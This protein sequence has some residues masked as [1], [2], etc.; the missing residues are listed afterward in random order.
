MVWRWTCSFEKYANA[1]KLTVDQIKTMLD[2]DSDIVV[3]ESAN[4]ITF[5][6]TVVVDP[7][8]QLPKGDARNRYIR[9]A[10]DKSKQQ[11][12]LDLTAGSQFGIH[13]YADVDLSKTSNG[14]WV[15]IKNASGLISSEKN[16]PKETPLTTDEILDTTVKKSADNAYIEITLP[17]SGSVTIK[18]IYLFMITN[19]VEGYA[20]MASRI[21]G[22]TGA[23]AENIYTV[24][25]AA[26]LYAAVNAVKSVTPMP[27]IIRVNGTITYDDWVAASGSTLRYIDLGSSV[28]NLTIVG[29]GSAG[30]FDG[31]G[32]KITGT[33]TIIQ[34][35]TITKV[36]GRDA[37]EINNAK[38]IMVDHCT[39]FNEPIVANPSEE[40]K[41]K[42]DE[43]ISAKN[44][45]EYIIISWNHFYNSYKTILVGSNDDADALPDRKMIMHHNYF[46]NCNS[47]LP[48]YRGGHAHIYNNYY[49]DILSDAINCRTGSK[50]RI[51]NNYFENVKKAIGYWHDTG[52]NPSGQW[53]VSGN[54]YVNVETDKPETST[55]TIDFGNYTYTLDPVD[56]VPGIVTA[57][58]GAGK[59]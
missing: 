33:N 6:S 7:V 22:G 16:V 15:R 45:A 11:G 40:L 5:T 4:G 46:Q 52:N 24:T 56:S 41:D 17:W 49:K 57:G 37:I 12:M 8:T 34:N 44:N 21:T 14:L 36:L 9:I 2:Y 19:K 30:K 50:L 28:S 20:D 25:N 48:L 18:N 3:T 47:R 23:A 53:Q 38:Y 59:I 58:A 10:Y 51:E 54:R 42:Y 35:L 39:L 13:V 27:S 29:V 32:F 43:L 26:E 55:C 1:Y 31:L